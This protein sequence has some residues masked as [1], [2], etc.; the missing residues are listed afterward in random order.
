MAPCSVKAKGRTG[1]NFRRA[2]LSHFAT[3]SGRHALAR[4]SSSMAEGSSSS[5]NDFMSSFNWSGLG[6]LAMGAVMPGRAIS[7]ARA[8]VAGAE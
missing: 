2:R 4:F 5:F 3:T 1:E 6:A 7:Q 8:T